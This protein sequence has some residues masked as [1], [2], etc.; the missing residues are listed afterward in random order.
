M[1]DMRID[2]KRVAHTLQ[3]CR[4]LL[5]REAST[6]RD[7][8]VA[9]QLCEATARRHADPPLGEIERAHVVWAQ[10]GSSD[11][12]F[13]DMLVRERAAARAD[14]EEIGFEEGT[15]EM[16]LCLRNLDA[17]LTENEALRAEIGRLRSLN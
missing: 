2:Y 12:Q 17:A 7:L 9:I 1:V 10:W 4:L 11:E 16:D 5:P 15:K 13:E 8:D 3:E 14:G 6:E